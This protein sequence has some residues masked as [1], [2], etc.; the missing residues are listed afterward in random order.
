MKGGCIMAELLPCPFCGAKPQLE[1][2]SIKL[3]DEKGKQCLGYLIWCS[4]EHHEVSVFTATKKDAINE[5]NTRT[6][7]RKRQ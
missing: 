6:P 5:W 7:K 3:V 2:K 4:G 1:E